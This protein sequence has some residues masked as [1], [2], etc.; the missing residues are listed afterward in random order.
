MPA[1]TS[2]DHHLWGVKRKLQATQITPAAIE[3][4]RMMVSCTSPLVSADLYKRFFR[5]LGDLGI[6]LTI[7]SNHLGGQDLQHLFEIRIRAVEPVTQV[8]NPEKIPRRFG[9]K[10]FAQRT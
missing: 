7:H 4:D 8:H 6:G 9:R 1:R 10:I 2:T 5:S 3:R